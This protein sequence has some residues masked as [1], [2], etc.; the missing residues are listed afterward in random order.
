MSQES[1]NWV[2]AMQVYLNSIDNDSV[3]SNTIFERKRSILFSVVCPFNPECTKQLLEY[4]KYFADGYF[5]P[6]ITDLFCISTSDQYIMDAWFKQNNINHVKYIADGNA[7]FTTAM[8][9]K[10]YHVFDG[11]GLRSTKYSCTIFDNVIEHILE[12]LRGINDTEIF[13][14]TETSPEKMVTYLSDRYSR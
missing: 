11:L 13:D 14:Y 1:V 3:I 5:E 2:P 4:E 12:P 7:G 6:H 10:T 9:K 8:M